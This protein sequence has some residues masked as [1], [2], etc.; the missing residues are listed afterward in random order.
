MCVYDMHI[1]LKKTK[2]GM[3]EKAMNCT[4]TRI[5][6]YIE[7]F[8]IPRNFRVELNV[9]LGLNGK[10]LQQQPVV[11]FKT[12]QQQPDVIHYLACLSTI[13]LTSSIMQKQEQQQ[14]QLPQRQQRQHQEQKQQ[15]QLELLL[16]PVCL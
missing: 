5:L 3:I 1:R 11:V 4:F 8:L 9:W 15:Q 14:K 16:S 10:T 2:P 6:C 13:N 12:L 7:D